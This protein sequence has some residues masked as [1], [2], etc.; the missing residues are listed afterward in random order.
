MRTGLQ[1]TRKINVQLRQQRLTANGRTNWSMITVSEQHLPR[2]SA[3]G[4]LP[5]N[6]FAESPNSYFRRTAHFAL[7]QGKILQGDESP[8]VQYADYF[9]ANLRINPAPMVEGRRTRFLR[10]DELIKRQA[11]KVDHLRKNAPFAYYHIESHRVVLSE[12]QFLDSRRSRKF[13]PAHPYIMLT[14]ILPG[15]KIDE[16][17][18]Q[19][20]VDPRLLRPGG[21]AFHPG[22]PTK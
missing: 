3:A 2:L 16:T 15:E 11:Q 14:P 12:S 8:L 4:V 19:I 13:S 5:A 1:Q 18:I 21:R 20:P 6:R 9:G 7:Q 17:V 10:R 22:Y